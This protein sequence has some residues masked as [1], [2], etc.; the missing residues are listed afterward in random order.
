MEIEENWPLSFVG[1]GANL[2]DA[3]DNALERAAHL[4]DM[5]I[6]EVKNRATIAGELQIGRYP[7]TVT[8]TFSVPEK[9]LEA[10]GLLEIV[11]TQYR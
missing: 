2:N 4:L 3:V 5:T 8:A 10:L 1:T 6:E 7:G 11:R 9:K